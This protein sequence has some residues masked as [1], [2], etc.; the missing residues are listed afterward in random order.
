MKKLATWTIMV[1]LVVIFF[2]QSAVA[3]LSIEKKDVIQALSEQDLDQCYNLA[4]T[5]LAQYYYAKD[6]G[7]SGE[8]HKYLTEDLY[9]YV[10]KKLEIAHYPIKKLGI[11]YSSHSSTFSLIDWQINEGRIIVEISA[12]I[13]HQDTGLGEI[14]A[15]G[16]RV[17]LIFTKMDGN[18]IITDWFAENPI[19][20]AVRGS[21]SDVL[22][23]ASRETVK[24]ADYDARM[25]EL[26]NSTIKY[27]E[28]ILD[29]AVAAEDPIISYD[30][31][32]NHTYVYTQG[33][34]AF[35]RNAMRTY[36][37]DN[38]SKVLPAKG[39]SQVPMYFDF[40]TIMGAFDCTNFISHVLLSGGT[41]VYNNGNRDTGWWFVDSDVNR[42]YSWSSVN[43]LYDFI[44]TNTI[45]GPTGRSF[46]YTRLPDPVD[47]SAWNYYE[48]GDIIQVNYGEGGY[49]YPGYGHSTVVT[50]F[51]NTSIRVLEPTIS[52]RTSVYSYHQNERISSTYGG[53]TL[54]IIR[55]EGY[56]N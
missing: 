4:Q 31:V 51:A 29:E 56:R 10:E 17:R 33:Q 13:T 9:K 22:A 44:T 46:A 16:E 41:P 24:F 36:A 42:S 1:L 26:E 45:K 20:L 18:L 23:S 32:Q 35:N 2:V 47:P 40:S 55:L 5:V 14:S 34:S 11:E 8:F 39:S 19:D 38:C 43:R 48:I 15:Y 54:R 37:I 28:V 6:H 25:N 21:Y 27:V 50:G 3:Q 52:S 49:G 12:R 53:Y 30:A 7:G